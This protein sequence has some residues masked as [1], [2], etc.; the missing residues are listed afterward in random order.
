MPVPRAHTG[1]AWPPGCPVAGARDREVDLLRWGKGFGLTAVRWSCRAEGCASS[2]DGAFGGAKLGGDVADGGAAGGEAADDLVL[3]GC[4]EVVV[5]DVVAGEGAFHGDF[6]DV[7][8][9]GWFGG[10]G[11]G[12]GV[13]VDVVPGQRWQPALR[14]GVG[15]GGLGGGTLRA[16]HPRRPG[17]PQ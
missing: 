9:L 8:A 5:G 2:G 12:C 4:G 11:G 16:G 14:G 17:V 6:V 10:P 1:R 15:S 3:F 13:G 7:V